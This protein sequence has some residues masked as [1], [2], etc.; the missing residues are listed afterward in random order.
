M[1]RYVAFS[2]N[3]NNSAHSAA[4]RKYAQLLRSAS[5]DLRPAF[6][7]AGLTVFLSSAEN[8]SRRPY[9][10]PNDT[11]IVVGRLFSGHITNDEESSDLAFTE[12]E[13]QLLIE[14]HGRRLVELYWGHY[15]AFL[16][17]ANRRH[18]FVLRDPTGAIPCF[19]IP[20][21]G[22]DIFLS[23]IEDCIPLRLPPFSINWDHV[24]AFFVHMRLITRTT[25][26]KGVNQLY[27]G[28]CMTFTD[29]D[30][31]TVGTR[32]FLWDPAHVC[33]ARMIGEPNDAKRELRA[34][35][36]YC[37][38]EWASCYSSLIHELSGGLDSSIVAACLAA[39]DAPPDVLCFHYFTEMSEGD[40]RRYARA[41]ASATDFP[42]FE[43]E[44]PVSETSLEEQL[45]KRR[46]AT[47]AELGFLP[48]S[49]AAKHRLATERKAGAIFSGQGG[50]HLFQ[51]S[52]TRLIAAEYLYR[53]GI[54]RG[55]FDTVKE[56]SHLTH[57]S[58]WSV[59]GT[60]I[61]YGLLRRSFDP[62]S[63]YDI[64]PIL[65]D[66]AR[67]SLTS[68][69]YIHPWIA[70]AKGL[71]ASKIRH[72]FNVIDC[73]PFYQMSYASTELIHPLISQPIIERCLQIPTYVL[74]HQGR[75][76]GLVRDAFEKDL[77]SE[78]TRRFSKGGTT[79]YFNRMLVENVAFLREFLLDG[80]LVRECILKRSELE[81][82]LTERNLILGQERRAILNA[83]RAE[84]W[85]SNWRDIKTRTAA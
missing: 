19:H 12:Q 13:S 49:E 33:E 50:D 25:G 1:L 34:A 24:T 35:I 36:R 77:P 5:P 52:R 46:F 69:E 29:V 63:M 3:A 39:G 71:P 10:L 6:D 61:R 73:Q 62:Y 55:L 16:R 47:P 30:T 51:E 75:S 11:G 67:A 23:D 20:T 64:P 22:I 68:Q 72:V 28:E 26:F 32:T 74:A 41:A 38:N 60:A 2:W 57:H 21:S 83:V 18:R 84:A 65:S 37:V 4:V 48:A 17:D 56:V 31:E 81:A 8:G 14:S 78:I 79:S 9:L 43:R 42:L 59:F 70:G 27:A 82:Q 66:E 15:V 53:N 40:E 44:L 7:V 45:M 58:F 76:R 80:T 54:R 85:L